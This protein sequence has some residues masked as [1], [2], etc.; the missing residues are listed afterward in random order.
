[1]FQETAE[2]APPGI[3]LSLVARGDGFVLMRAA[4]TDM[5]PPIVLRF[6]RLGD[7]VVLNMRV[8]DNPGLVLTPPL[9]EASVLLERGYAARLAEKAGQVA[10]GAAARAIGAIASRPALHLPEAPGAAAAVLQ[11]AREATSGIADREPARIA[12]SAEIHAALYFTL[13]HAERTGLLGA[14]PGGGAA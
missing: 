6:V 4:L 10:A 3:A 1:M 5:A 14:P 13:R 12:A 9:T 11:A 7:G 2:P 8:A